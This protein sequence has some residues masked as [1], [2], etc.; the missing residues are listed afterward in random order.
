[1]APLQSSSK[2]SNTLTNSLKMQ[3]TAAGLLSTLI[4]YEE[5]QQQKDVSI[6]DES[7]MR[8]T[9]SATT[10]D[11]EKTAENDTQDDDKKND[12]GIDMPNSSDNGDLPPAA[13]SGLDLQ[14][15]DEKTK[16]LIPKRASDSSN[17]EGDGEGGISFDNDANDSID[18]VTVTT[19]KQSGECYRDKFISC[20]HISFA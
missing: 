11:D 3:T 13:S 14:N 5:R 15:L 12:K 9:A 16:K 20:V 1:M 18:K 8:T 2:Q 10:D 7:L 17:S 6:N 4:D 19:T